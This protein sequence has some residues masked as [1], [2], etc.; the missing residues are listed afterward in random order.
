MYKFTNGIV[1]YDEKTFEEYKAAGM[2]PVEE[3][4]KV[5]NEQKDSNRFEHK[6]PRPSLRTVR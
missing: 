6:E 4:K 2:I 5:K 3:P 1:V